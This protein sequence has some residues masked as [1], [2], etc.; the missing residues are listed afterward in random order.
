MAGFFQA[1][2]IAEAAINI[3]QKG[4][5]FYA[6]AAQAAKNPDVK[7]FFLYFAKEEARHEQIF[8]QLKDRLDKFELPAWSTTEEYGMYL[9]ALIDSHSIFSPELQRRLAEAANENEAIRLAMGFE[10]DT[11][12]FFME[13]KDLVPDTE[14][15]FVTQCIDEERSHLRQLSK[16]LT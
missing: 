16:M 1:A 11:I 4:Q 12:L 14:K 6:S 8:Q 10:K 9:K 7:D 5:A 15:K 2:E 3:E 13:M